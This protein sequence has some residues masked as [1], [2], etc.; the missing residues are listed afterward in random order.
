MPTQ[1]ND[2]LIKA[3]TTGDVA[4]LRTGLTGADPSEETVQSLLVAA[5]SDS[6][7]D[8]TEFLLAQYPS[9][10]L[11]EEVVRA[12][13]NTGS[14][15]IFGALLARDPACINMQFDMRGSPLIVACMGQQNLE[16]LKYLLEA[17]ADPNQDPDAAAYPLALVAALYSEVA[18]VDLLLQHGARI[19]YSGALAAAAQRGNQTMLCYLLDRG[20]R[21]QTDGPATS[22]KTPVLHVA[23]KAGHTEV[24]RVLL[25]HGADLNEKDASGVS[26]IELVKNM[27]S[28][29]KDMNEMLIIL[30]ANN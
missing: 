28:K 22:P 26:A 2:L 29:G 4:L 23:V 3:A 13:V 12:A 14:M 15:A 20:A 19:E 8:I 6:Q 21:P 24:A 11:N 17:G 9:V 7:I 18:A 27:Q 5:V 10:P 16:Y 1:N 25:E 30:G